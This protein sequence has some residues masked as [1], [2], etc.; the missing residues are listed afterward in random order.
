MGLSSEST[1]TK[2]TFPGQHIKQRQFRSSADSQRTL[3]LRP[4]M[5]SLVALKRM[6][7]VVFVAHVALHAQIIIKADVALPA[8]ATDPVLLAAIAD[9]VGVADA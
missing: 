5:G 9:D 7:E 2:H 1:Q 6:G 8:H 4:R 3:D